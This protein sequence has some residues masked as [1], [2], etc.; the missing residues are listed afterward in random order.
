[1]C[2]RKINSNEGVLTTGNLVVLQLEFLFAMLFG[3]ICI[4]VSFR[5]SLLLEQRGWHMLSAF[6]IT[7]VPGMRAGND[8]G[9]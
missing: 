8:E 5:S 2:R 7:S 3:F 4:D 1:M 9:V 6:E